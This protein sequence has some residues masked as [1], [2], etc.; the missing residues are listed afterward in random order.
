MR[1][2]KIGNRLLSKTAAILKGLKL[3]SYLQTW[4]LQ[5][6]YKFMYLHFVRSK[7][8]SDELVCKW[9]KWP[10]KWLAAIFKCPIII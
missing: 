2:V 9:L 10:K 8:S 3:L 7:L 1:M 5:Y 4:S 6:L